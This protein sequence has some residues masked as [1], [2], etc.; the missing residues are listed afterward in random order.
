VALTPQLNATSLNA[1]DPVCPG[2]S[3]LPAPFTLTGANLNTTDITVGPLAGFTFATSAGGPYTASLTLTATSGSLTQTVY[4]TFSPAAVGSY[5]GNIPVRGGGVSSYNVPV[6]ASS[7]SIP[8]VVVTGS[9][10]VYSANEAD[11]YGTIT[12]S[13][14]GAVIEQGIEYSGINGFPVGFGTR[15]PA[16]SVSGQDFTVSLTNLVPNTYYYYRAYAKNGSG[17]GYGAQELFATPDLPGGLAIYGNPITRG[18]TIHYSYNPVN[19]GHYSV[20]IFNCIGQLVFK[21]DL[22]IQVNFIDDM[23]RVPA[24]L[25]TGLYILQI[26]NDQ[27]RHRRPFMI[28]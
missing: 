9:S 2:Q 18:G 11:L 19:P 12:N 5:S 3:S 14:C 8:P 16:T 25:G 1:F 15:V 13:G 26:D 21:R 4:V 20:K 24:S 22:V 7:V 28:R 10:D 27:F 23:F 17:T 6:T